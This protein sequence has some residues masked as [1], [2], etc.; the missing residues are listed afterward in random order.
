MIHL[1]PYAAQA[2][3]LEHLLREMILKINQLEDLMDQ[4]KV[5]FE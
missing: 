4:I 2:N 1:C 5:E 3:D